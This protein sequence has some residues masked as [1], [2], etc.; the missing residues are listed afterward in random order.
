[1]TDVAVILPVYNAGHYLDAAIRSVL[2]QTHADFTLC[3]I[4]DGSTDG[5][6]RVLEKYAA[7]D[8]R[9]RFRSRENKGLIDT[10]N[11]LAGMIGARY[12][13]RMDADDICEPQRFAEL[14]GFMQAN[15]DCVACGSEVL[16]I[17]PFDRPL[18]KMGEMWAHEEIDAA[19]LAGAGGAIIH[20][21]SII[22]VSAFNSVGG[23]RKKYTHA[24][25]IDLFLRLAEQ[26]RLANIP[27]TLLR[28]RQHF[29]SVGYSN[30]LQQRRST[31][32]A[33]QDAYARRGIDGVIRYEPEDAEPVTERIV[34]SKWAWWALS[35]GHLATARHY[36]TK[37]F[38]KNVFSLGSWKLIACVLRESLKPIHGSKPV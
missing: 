6:R 3:I 8:A 2:N 20:P 34:F 32:N 16:L 36:A 24:E 5:S 11:E 37:V 18:R 33:I 9:I 29:S 30:R 26:G 28:Y 17:D 23:Y 22:R 7:Q 27:L 19:H 35:A 38:A 25:D 15:D 12:L 10:L 14:V 31:L 13:I 21:A 1:M 4:D